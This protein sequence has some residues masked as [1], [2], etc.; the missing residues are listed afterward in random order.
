VPARFRALDERDRTAIYR[1]ALGRYL[2]NS[3]GM[4]TQ[5]QVI[6]V[7]LNGGS[8]SEVF[9]HSLPPSESTLEPLKNW[10]VGGGR[11]VDVDVRTV[12]TAVRVEASEGFHR[13]HRPNQSG[14]SCVY[15]I[16]QDTSGRWRIT[17][18]DCAIL[19]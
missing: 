10:K 15:T 16:A 17:S 14:C 12:D 6:Y 18:E 1:T 4:T 13:R 7:S 9:L 3:K 11:L 5:S 8:P 19:E 2:E